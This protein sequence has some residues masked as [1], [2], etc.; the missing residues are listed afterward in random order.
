[1]KTNFLKKGFLLLGVILSS[2]FISCAD[3]D[4]GSIT[5]PLTQNEIREIAST[6][7][8]VKTMFF[9]FGGE[10]KDVPTKAGIKTTLTVNGKKYTG[11][12]NV[13]YSGN[14]LGYI[15]VLKYDFNA[16]DKFKIKGETTYNVTLRSEDTKHLL[17]SASFNI[18]IVN[19]GK[20]VNK[21]GNIKFERTEGN[22]TLLD[23]KDDVYETSGAWSFTGLDGVTTSATITK[24]LVR[25]S[26]F[27]DCPYTTQGTI[28]IQKGAEKH[29]L[30]YGNGE[31]DNAVTLDGKEFSLK[32]E[33]EK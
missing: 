32:I 21:K 25:K 29:I 30:D 15:K 11:Y 23:K 3:E 33:V 13:K 8:L 24:N 17:A 4:N 2:T 31:C 1:M 26:I 5:E 27:S 19:N 28:V 14:G 18:T 9:N 7:N 22:E 20:E 16:D 12:I 6:K 10:E